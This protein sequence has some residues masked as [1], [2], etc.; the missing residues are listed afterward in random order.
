[1]YHAFYPE[2]RILK[3]SA[4]LWNLLA[5]YLFHIIHPTSILQIKKKGVFK[6]FALIYTS[7]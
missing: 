5:K 6:W 3:Q 7:S 4:Y 1:M 2:P